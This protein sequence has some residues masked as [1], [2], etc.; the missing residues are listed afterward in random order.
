MHTHTHTH[1]HRER[2]RQTDKES[3]SESESERERVARGEVGCA[4]GKITKTDRCFQ[5]DRKNK[6]KGHTWSD[7]KYFQGPRVVL[8]EINANTVHLWRRRRR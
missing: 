5:K 7:G 8:I 1:T 3:E 4:R 6:N 2:E